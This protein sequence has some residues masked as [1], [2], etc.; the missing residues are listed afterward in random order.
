MIVRDVERAAAG[1][2]DVIVVG[3]GVYGCMTALESCA[4]GL[5]PLLIESRDFGSRTSF[6]SFRLIHGGLR[7]LQS[8]DIVRLRESVQERSWFLRRFPGLVMPIPCL[9]PLYGRGLRR[10]SVMRLA[11]MANELLSRG[12]NSGLAEDRCLPAGRVLNRSE[13]LAMCPGI[14]TAGLEGAAVWWDASMPDSQR[15]LLEI[16]HWAS[17][18]GATVLNYVQAERLLVENGRAC[19]IVALDRFTGASCEF[20]GQ[21]VINAAGPWVRQT[22]ARFDRDYDELFHPTLAWNVL[23]DRSPPSDCVLALQADAAGHTYFLRPFKGRLLAGTG[24]APWQGGADQAAPSRAQ[25][26]DMLGSLNGAMP[27]LELDPGQIS[28]VFAGLLPG[29]GAGDRQLAVRPVIIDH[30]KHGGVRNLVSVSGVKFT[31]ARRVAEAVLERAAGRRTARRDIT[32]YQPEA[33]GA[34]V[35]SCRP[36]LAAERGECLSGLRRLV[37]QEAV[38][39]LDDLVLRRTTLW[40]S[41]DLTPGMTDALCGLFPWDEIRKGKELDRLAAAFGSMLASSAATMQGG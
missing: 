7:Y 32:R 3:G 4:R 18:A 29:R 26:M 27:G 9:L 5:R 28:R 24:H 31:T 23:F 41:A 38:V 10:N 21:L 30:G 40:E 20:R 39:H 35:W 33:V 12:Q 22:A 2:Y 36:E 8:L 37:A 16:L 6:N 1:T 34:D 17:A 15:L 13:T 14:A 25:L 11:L 19:G